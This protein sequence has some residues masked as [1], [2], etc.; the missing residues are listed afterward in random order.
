MPTYD[1]IP[2]LAVAR[3]HVNIGW[4]YLAE[5]LLRD[6]LRYG[7]DV[8]P[9]FQRAHVWNEEQKARY[10]EYILRGGQSGRDI[11]LNCPGHHYGRIGPDYEDGWFVLVDG[12][13]R[14]DA[15][16]GFMNNEFKIFGQ[17]YRRDFTDRMRIT[18]ACFNWHIA[19]LKTIEEV[20]Q[21]YLDLNSGGT[22]HTEKDLSKVRELLNNKEPYVRISREEA[23]DQIGLNHRDYLKDTLAAEK[24]DEEA[25]KV[26]LAKAEERRAQEALDKKASRKVARKAAKK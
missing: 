18:T 22:V 11:Y 16:L 4:D 7:L 2:Q 23:A 26:A 8:N 14:L 3:Y 17:W 10:V 20:Y 15:A 12:K 13:Q 21:W 24:R 6:T 1:Q 19:D 25:R 5:H 9:N